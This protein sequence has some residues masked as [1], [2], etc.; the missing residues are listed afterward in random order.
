MPPKREIRNGLSIFFLK[1]VVMEKLPNNSETAN[2]PVTKPPINQNAEKIEGISASHRPTF[3]RM[4][5]SSL[6]PENMTPMDLVQDV[7]IPSIRDGIFDILISSIDH[8]RGGVGGSSVITNNRRINGSVAT[9]IS[10]GSTNYNK[11]SRIGQTY[12]KTQVVVSSPSYDDIFIKDGVDKNGKFVSGVV[13]AQTVIA[14]LDD[15]ISRYQVARVSD[16]FKYCGLSPS[17]N[18]SDFNWGWTNLDSAGY[19]PKKGGALLVLP[20]AMQIE[21]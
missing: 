13:R 1:G 16:L 18:G 6:I 21:D 11:I 12:E 7:V 17:P 10:S 14:Q 4:L 5:K 9:R 8:W 15:D 2:K 3:W 19:E 20:E